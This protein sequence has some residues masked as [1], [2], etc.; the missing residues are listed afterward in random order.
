VSLMKR[1][2]LAVDWLLCFLTRYD[3]SGRHRQCM[4]KTVSC[5]TKVNFQL[6]L[7]CSAN[8]LTLLVQKHLFRG[9]RRLPQHGTLILNFTAFP[10]VLSIFWFFFHFRIWHRAAGFCAD[11]TT[12]WDFPVLHS[13]C[14]IFA[15]AQLL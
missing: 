11:S 1:V 5:W 12:S 8:S 14:N 9:H 10:L 7:T 3:S 13:Q 6:P 4:L 2:G 15:L